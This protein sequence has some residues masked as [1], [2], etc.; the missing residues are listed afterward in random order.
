MVKVI[1]RLYKPPLEEELCRKIN[2][3]KKFQVFLML[4]YL[5][6]SFTEYKNKVRSK[7]FI[8]KADMLGIG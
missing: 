7:E 5:I 1:F 4:K 3:K 2:L 8:L 6:F